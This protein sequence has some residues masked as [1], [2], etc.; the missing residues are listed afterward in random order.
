M[1]LKSIIHKKPTACGNPQAVGFYNREKENENYSTALTASNSAV[2]SSL[3]A[4]VNFET[5]KI[6]AV[7]RRNA[8]RSS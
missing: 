1:G 7:E 4:L 2:I 6:T 5:A 8:G 3:G